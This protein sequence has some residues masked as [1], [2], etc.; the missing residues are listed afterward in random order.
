MK[1][2]EFHPT[3]QI[4]PLLEPDSIGFQEL[5][6]SIRSNGLQNPITLF[7]GMILDGRHRFLACR[8]AKVE[9]RFETPEITGYIA[10]FVLDQGVRRSLTRTERQIASARYAL[11]IA[12]E[13]KVRRTLGTSSPKRDEGAEYGRTS[14]KAAAKFGVS[15]R[16]VQRAADVVRYSPELADVEAGKV[17]LS[18]AAERVTAKRREDA[19]MKPPVLDRSRLTPSARAYCQERFRKRVYNLIVMSFTKANERDGLTQKT[20]GERIDK[21]PAQISR[22]LS[23]PQNLTL[24]TVCD[25]L[26]GVA[27]EELDLEIVQRRVADGSS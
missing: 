12:K 27:G 1:E 2:Y 6:E 9:P 21:T 22:A 8:L 16:T 3:A 4:F 10:D 7:D 23:S 26:L 19:S 15:P 24:D 20:L 13:A 11:A 5:V 17:S 25:L 14:A 18:A